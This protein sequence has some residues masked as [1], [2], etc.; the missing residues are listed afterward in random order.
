[1][2]ISLKS[3]LKLWTFLCLKHSRKGKQSQNKETKEKN[4]TKEYD[5]L[6]MCSFQHSKCVFKNCSDDCISL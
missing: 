4:Q 3:I 5:M 1:M 2:Q 6:G